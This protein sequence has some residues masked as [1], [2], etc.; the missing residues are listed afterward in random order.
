M[1]VCMMFRYGWY[2]V[3][4]EGRKMMDDGCRSKEGVY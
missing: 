2:E 3:K 1:Y 4:E